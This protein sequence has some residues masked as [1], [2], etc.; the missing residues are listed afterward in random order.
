MSERLKAAG[1]DLQ[2][3]E[4]LLDA[5]VLYSLSLDVDQDNV[6]ALSNRALMNLKVPPPKSTPW[7]TR[8]SCN[9]A[10]ALH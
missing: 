8:T 3:N 6:K 5:K 4:A 9:P 2:K 7:G 1:N 10:P